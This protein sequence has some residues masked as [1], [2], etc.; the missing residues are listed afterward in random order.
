MQ[1][2]ADLRGDGLE[3]QAGPSGALTPVYRRR[4][5]GRT[6]GWAPESS[7]LLV[8][9]TVEGADQV[10]PLSSEWITASEFESTAVY[11]M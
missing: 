3:Q 2:G 6:A 5:V 8:G 4:T 11:A 1:R 10:T 7:S 9:G